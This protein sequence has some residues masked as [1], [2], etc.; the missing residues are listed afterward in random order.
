MDT[1]E[2][3]PPLVGNRIVLVGAVL[4]LLE[5]VAIFVAQV[6]VPIGTDA[7]GSQLV[8]AYAVHQDALGWA[9]GWFSVVLLGRI[10]IVIGLRAALAGTGPRQ[11]LLDFALAAMVVG[12]V[13]EIASY[14]I[15]AGAS[16]AGSEGAT[17]GQLRMVD[18]VAYAMTGMLWGPTGIAIVCCA[19]AMRRFQ[20]FPRTLVT[21]GIVG[22]CLM[23]L[24]G[25]AFLAPRYGDVA[26]VLSIAPA[27]F[28]VWMLWTGVL[29]W[30][31]TEKPVPVAA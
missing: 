9:A 25:V 16:W 14:A 26:A 4:Y 17:P 23:A 13:V 15:V 31:R 8:D 18:S 12:V 20:L 5:W 21:V 3:Q 1:V 10:L 28:W 7:T 24:L 19:V 27:L 11:P 29:L 22:G 30:R 6:A 2:A